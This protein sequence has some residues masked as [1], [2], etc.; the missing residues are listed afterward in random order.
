MKAKESDY[1]WRR[2][3]QELQ[4]AVDVWTISLA[5]SG[6]V[7]LSPDEAARAARFH[8]EK[9]RIRWTAARSTLRRVL[10]SYLNTSPESLQFHYGENGK[11]ALP[12]IEFN[13]S[14]SGDFAMIAV[15]GNVPVGIDIEHMRP[16]VDIAKLLTRLGE[17]N[18]PDSIPELYS[19]WTRREA[20]TKAIGGQLF[21]T[22]ADDIHA[23]DVPAPAGYSAAVALVGFTPMVRANI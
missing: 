3:S 20:I 18:L 16:G 14:H 7:Y 1:H 12:A 6:P 11:P 22:P 9:D 21:A 23:V 19:R 10:A 2:Y 4:H 15:A 17:T 8:F 5:E 13:L